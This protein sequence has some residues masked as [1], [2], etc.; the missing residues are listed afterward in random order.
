[1]AT[2]YSGTVHFTSSDGQAVLPDDATLTNGTGSFTVTLLTAGTQS[3]TASDTVNRSIMG[4]S[5]TTVSP[6]AASQF[7]VSA[8]AS[9]TAG[10]AFTATV[11]AFDAF[12]N[13][14]TGYSGTVHFTSSD[15]QAV[16]PDDATLT[17][18]TGSF[19]VALL[20]AGTQSVTATDTVN[21]SITGFATVAVSPAAATHLVLS[22]SATPVKNQDWSVTVTAYDAFG[23]VATGYTGTITFSSSD[24]KAILP[25]D[26]TFTAA[27]A[28]TSTFSVTFHGQHFQSVTVTD[29]LNANIFGMIEV[30]VDNPGQD[31]H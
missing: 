18:G 11:T 1:V 9:A 29:T 16:L 27:D 31:G 17:N 14:A 15:G 25:A 26:F 30:F 8:P 12:G 13:V 19:T 28:G 24:D 23:N 22:D 4:S 20:T 10:V 7:V 21:G 6:A 5:T 2:G 3:V